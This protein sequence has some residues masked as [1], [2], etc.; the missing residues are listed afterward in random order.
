[1]S[2]CRAL[3]LQ[4]ISLT[5]GGT[6]QSNYLGKSFTPFCLLCHWAV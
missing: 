2:V 3:N 1:M 4:S 6:L 5:L